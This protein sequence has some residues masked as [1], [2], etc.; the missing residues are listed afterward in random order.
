MED[1]SAV[2]LD[3]FWRGWFYTTDYAD[4]SIDEV[5][6]FKVK[7]ETRDVESKSKNVKQGTLGATGDNSGKDSRD[8]S[9]GPEYITVLPTDDRFYGDFRARMDDQA[10]ISKLEN[11]NLYEITISNQGGLIMPVV[12]EWTFT[13]GTKE[14]EILPAEIWRL[15]EKKVTKVFMKDKEVATVIVD[16]KN[17]IADVNTGDNAFP[18]A[19]PINKFD[20]LKKK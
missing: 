3:W 2:D 17:E 15:N 10:M 1:A 6:W 9:N 18:K 14:T 19:T 7:K 13:D 12:I 4:Q 20:Q 8:F 16:P 11:K 5:K